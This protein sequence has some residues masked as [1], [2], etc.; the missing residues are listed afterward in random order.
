V[1]WVTSASLRERELHGRAA[2]GRVQVSLLHAGL[3]VVVQVSTPEDPR[4]RPC[5]N[6][7]AT[8][9]GQKPVWRRRR[10]PADDVLITGDV[11]ER[12][13]SVRHVKHGCALTAPNQSIH[14]GHGRQLLAG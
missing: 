3:A 13:M 10:G 8:R 11:G 9:R 5:S 2:S 14:P 12:S 6:Q 4:G 1:P 7:G